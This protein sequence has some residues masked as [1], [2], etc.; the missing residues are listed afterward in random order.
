[1]DA[2]PLE[3]TAFVPGKHFGRYEVLCELARGGMGVVAV[4]RLQG[5]HGVRR[6]V[7]LKI[8]HPHLTADEQYSRMFVREAEIASQVHHGN[9]VPVI[10]LGQ[11]GAQYFLVMEYFPSLSLLQLMREAARRDVLIP[12]EFSAAVVADACAGLHAAHEL[13]DARGELLGVVHRDA[14][15]SNLLL[16]EDGA[17]KVTDFGVARAASAMVEQLTGESG[18]AKGKLAYL[19]PEQVHGE[20][21]DRRSDLF[22]LGVVLYELLGRKALFRADNELALARA[23]VDGRIPDVRETNPDVPDVLATV[24]SRALE[25]DRT[26]R[27]Q[28]AA[29]M[30]DALLAALHTLPVVSRGA[31][32]RQLLGDEF[33]ARREEIATAEAVLGLS[34]SAISSSPVSGRISIAASVRGDAPMSR[35]AE[36]AV[37]QPATP[38][39]VAASQSAPPAASRSVPLLPPHATSKSPPPLPG[40]EQ[41][42]PPPLPA[43][44]Q[45]APPA[46]PVASRSAAPTSPD[47]ARNATPTAVTAVI[48]TRDTTERRWIA[49]LAVVAL[50]GAG[51]VALASMR[52]APESATRRPMEAV[53]TGA[54][55]AQA[56]RELTPPA[57]NVPPVVTPPPMPEMSDASA[58][59]E[60]TEQTSDAGEAPRHVGRPTSH[61]SPGASEP[62]AR[63]ARLDRRGENPA[64]GT[65]TTPAVENPPSTN[66][67]RPATP[68]PGETP[69]PIAPTG[70]PRLEM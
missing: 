68:A 16:G 26:R 56:R 24:V 37:T 35:S 23:I 29:E 48:A 14:T 58:P 34:R 69:A 15:P 62:P 60:P 2:T 66:V 47:P 18:V 57:A 21:T 11:E 10:E 19:S 39:A 13:R 4:G 33:S 30:H 43:A 45:S 31:F 5:A 63:P 70:R 12:Y 54:S 1:M 64:T 27:F 65:P 41:S 55:E 17:V 25:R 44:L 53:V 61:A 7:A 46:P 36:G 9:V 51:A 40:V 6:L 8:I 49:P 67:A 38:A 50:L 3:P 42:A 32:V 22:T 28:T 20:E 52:A 59:S